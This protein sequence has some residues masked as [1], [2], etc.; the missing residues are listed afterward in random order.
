MPKY[1]VLKPIALTGQP[2]HS[3]ATVELSE[4]QARYL[5]LS[6]KIRPVTEKTKPATPAA[7]KKED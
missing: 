6:G 7:K 1:T 5:L 2:G 3:G 4:R